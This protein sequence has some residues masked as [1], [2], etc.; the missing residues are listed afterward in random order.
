MNKADLAV[1]PY[2][3]SCDLLS[4]RQREHQYSPSTLR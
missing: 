4:G 3:S 1:G 2:V